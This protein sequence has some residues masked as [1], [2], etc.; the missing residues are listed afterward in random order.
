[1]ARPNSAALEGL[2]AFLSQLP[3]GLDKN[4]SP[5]GVALEA[6]LF[7]EPA[8][9]RRF[10]IK[11]N[12]VPVVHDGPMGRGQRPPSPIGAGRQQGGIGAIF[13]N[14]VATL[15]QTVGLLVT[16]CGREVRERALFADCA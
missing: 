6:R 14:P 12:G 13:G 10:S 8:H 11:A 4:Q 16:G 3:P 7:L 2:L 15:H 1:M 5:P 9:P